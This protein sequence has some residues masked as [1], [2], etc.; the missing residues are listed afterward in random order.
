MQ[1]PSFRCNRTRR[2]CAGS[3]FLFRFRSWRASQMMIGFH[4]ACDAPP[5]CVSLTP[6][7]WS[8]VSTSVL[9]SSGSNPV[10]S[11]DGRCDDQSNREVSD[12]QK[13]RE[14]N[15]S[16]TAGMETTRGFGTAEVIEGRCY[17]G[18]QM[19]QQPRGPQLWKEQVAGKQSM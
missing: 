16:G 11:A 6:R 14:L 13:L 12:A 5:V 7:N 18:N 1:G 9:T 10:L 4:A 8:I 15:S 17:L 3:N 19:Q 2:R